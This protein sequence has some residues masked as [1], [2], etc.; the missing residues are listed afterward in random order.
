MSTYQCRWTTQCPL[1]WSL[2]YLD[3]ISTSSP[4]LTHDAW[5]SNR[6]RRA[7][8]YAAV[9]Q[10]L[11]LNIERWLGAVDMTSS[12]TEIQTAVAIWCYPSWLFW[13]TGNPRPFLRYMCVFFR[14]SISSYVRYTFVQPLS[15]SVLACN[16][17]TRTLQQTSWHILLI[18]IYLS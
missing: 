3:S 9:R 5:H 17:L 8:A 10:E 6:H 16:S 2:R 14:F 1:I 7:Q 4:I 15:L 12:G 11:L 13:E 18:E